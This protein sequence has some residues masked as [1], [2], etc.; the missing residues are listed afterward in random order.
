MMRKLIIALHLLLLLFVL[1]C[2]SGSNDKRPDQMKT[3]EQEMLRDP[4]VSLKILNNINHEM[5]A[6]SKQVRMEYELLLIQALDKTGHSLV[7]CQTKIDSVLDYFQE[8]GTY[9]QKAKSYYYKGGYYRDNN[10]D[11]NAIEWYQKAWKEINKT[12]LHTSSE[13]ELAAVICAQISSL[14]YWT[15]N[16]TE[17]L[18]YAI[19]EYNHSATPIG[20]FEGACDLARGYKGIVDTRDDICD[21]IIKYYD[22]AFNLSKALNLKGPNYQYNL[23]NQAS[24]FLDLGMKEKAI[25]RLKLLD[26]GS[27]ANDPSGYYTLGSIYEGLGKTDSALYYYHKTTKTK[28]YGQVSAAYGRLMEH[29]YKKGN[30]KAAAEYALKLKVANDSAITQDDAERVSRNL[31]K[32]EKSGIVSKTK[33]LRSEIN[34]Q[35]IILIVL[36]SFLVGTSGLM[37]WWKLG[38]N[39]KFREKLSKL[40]EERLNMEKEI[41][42]TRKQIAEDTGVLNALETRNMELRKELRELE[43]AEKLKRPDVQAFTN[44]I[45]ELLSSGSM[46]SNTMCEQLTQ[47]IIEL[48]PETERKMKEYRSRNPMYATILG[49]SLLGY[50]NVDISKLT[51]NERNNVTNYFYKIYKDITGMKYNKNTD[52]VSD[53]RYYLSKDTSPEENENNREEE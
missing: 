36:I 44:S 20:K 53:I 38:N 18:K 17:S 7:N 46:M 16:Y 11:I 25:E 32:I 48:F 33:A 14:L 43:D 40:K 9:L 6:Y 8:E 21:S 47:I 2:H 39:R 42:R 28:D 37:L 45:D 5:P 49:L 50:R 23:F 34:V 31:E 26:L 10:D 51:G 1:S 52:F 15:S 19:L 35:R 3:A 12:S 30:W 22:I 27:F 29:E 4:K 41:E 24:F 13:K